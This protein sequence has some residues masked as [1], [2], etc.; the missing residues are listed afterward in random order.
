MS[1]SGVDQTYVSIALNENI[2]NDDVHIYRGFLDT[3]LALISDPFLLF[4]G[5]IDEYKIT[6][7]Y[8]NSKNSINSNITLG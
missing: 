1:L 3:N 8:I 4:F 5:T 7:T 2:I 6:D